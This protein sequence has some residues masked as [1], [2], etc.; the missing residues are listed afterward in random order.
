MAAHYSD[1]WYRVTRAVSHR[2]EGSMPAAS[3]VETL[4]LCMQCKHGNFPDLHAHC[5]MS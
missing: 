5:R 4:V 2:G 3:M 1:D